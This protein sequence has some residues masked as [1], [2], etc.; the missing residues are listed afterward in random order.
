MAEQPGAK[1]GRNDGGILRLVHQ[2]KLLAIFQRRL[3]ILEERDR[4]RISV[5]EIR[6][7]AY[8]VLALCQSPE[9]QS[10]Q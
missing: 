5:V 10:E 3:D 4:E 7:V 1:R 2:R 9:E 6:N 8:D